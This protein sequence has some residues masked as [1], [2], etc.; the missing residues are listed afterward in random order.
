M[1]G[2]AE[3]LVQVLCPHNTVGTMVMNFV[4]P[5]GLSVYS[6]LNEQFI[7]L[8]KCSVCKSMIRFRFIESISCCLYAMSPKQG[9]VPSCKR[10]QHGILGRTYD[11]NYTLDTLFVFLGKVLG[12]GF[13]QIRQE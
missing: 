1:T 13:M 12:H 6:V 2:K 8:V 4:K 10:N 3:P 11:A 7:S 5:E 9:T